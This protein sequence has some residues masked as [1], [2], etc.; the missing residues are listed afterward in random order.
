MS[1]AQKESIPTINDITWTDHV[2]ELLS[3]DE[4][5]KGNPTTDGLRRVFEI[6]LDCTIIGST[7]KICQSPEPENGNRATVVHSLGYVL[8]DKSL[9]DTIKTRTVDGSADVY[10]GNC[11]KIFR[12]HPV[13]VAETRAEGRA[14]RRALRLRKVVAA[15]EIAEEVEDLDGNT[16]NKITNNQINF[17]DVMSKRLN[18]NVTKLLSE[19]N[20]D[21]N[22]YTV[23]HSDAVGIIRQL[24][25]YQQDM[26][27]ISEN[28][29]GYNNEWK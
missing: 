16:V 10:W 5:I 7:S 26:S 12:N 6:A 2:L 1:K 25:K 20:L 27:S 18:I 8:N 21:T 29:T 24:S 17:I 4:K 23:S 22:I 11:D 9:D 14:L 28:I 19:Q 3:D 15:E 13:A